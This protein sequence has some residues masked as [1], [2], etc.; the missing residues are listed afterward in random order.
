MKTSHIL[1]ALVAI[2]TLTGM[3]ATDVLLKRQYTTIDWSDPY[4]T[5]ERRALP[6][7]RHLVIDTAPIAEVIVEQNPRPQAL[8]LP[9]MADSY[10]TRQQGDT[11]F[12]SFTMNY[13]G[14]KRSPRNTSAYELPA[15]L[16]LRLPDVES[17]R[18]I[19]GCLTLRKTTLDSLAVSL[20]NTRLRT[21]QVIVGNALRLTENQ[22]SFALLRADRYQ[23]LQAMVRDSSGLQLDNTQMQA[24]TPQVS[25][26]AEVQLRGQ[27]LKWLK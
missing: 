3:V 6:A 27:A 4:Q 23:S 5:F 25:P 14:E 26:K 18:M 2:I 7:V 17:I 9:A 21:S 24:F 13:K 11:L 19:N 22:N 16:V 20:V 10:R 15:G 12:V 1:L 8:L